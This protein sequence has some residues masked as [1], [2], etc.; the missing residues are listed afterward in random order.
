[1]QQ[2]ISDSIIYVGVDDKDLDLFESQYLVP[3]GITYNSYVILD[4]KV[5]VFDTVDE[6]KVDEWFAS[7]QGAL[8][9]RTPDY[10]VVTHVEPDHSAGIAKLAAA[11]PSMQIVGNAKTF[12][13]IDAFFSLD[14]LGERSVK[15]AEG[16]SLSLGEHELTF[17]MA[18]MVHWPE[19]MVAYESKSRTLFSADAFGKFG[20]SDAS[21][22]WA[23]EA[24]RYYYNIVGKYGAN[25]QTLLKKLAG[26]DV[27]IIAPLH[28]PILR[29]DIAYYVKMYDMWSTYQAEEDSIL[30]CHASIHGN[31]AEVA[32]EL[33]RILKAKGKE[34]VELCDLTRDDMAQAVED[35]F[36]SQTLVLAAS[37]YD[38][39]LFPPMVHYLHHLK[40]KRFQNR[41]VALIQNGSWGPT[42]A[43]VMRAKLEEMPKI[44]IL[45]PEVTIR[46]RYK[47]SDAAALEALA[48]ALIG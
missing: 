10:L 13:L 26:L 16:E 40:D 6:R 11:Y 29:E 44:T 14:G 36:Y 39:G 12:G 5:A 24:R 42:A 28:G 30:I 21:G 20:A 18:P 37:S 22:S 31:T 34:N 35:A 19:V 2:N 27:S 41:R 23:C 7:L 33:Q 48:D 47:P 17:Y 4:E 3:E 15:V 32:R 45:E 8:A 38:G 9:S 46:S 43:K 25:V 1:M